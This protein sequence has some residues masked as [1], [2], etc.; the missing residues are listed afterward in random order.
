MVTCV[1]PSG[2]SR[3]GLNPE[4]VLATELLDAGAHP[5]LALLSLQVCACEPLVWAAHTHVAPTA[6]RVRLLSQW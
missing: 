6:R 2:C 4:L 5:E 1:M 3:A